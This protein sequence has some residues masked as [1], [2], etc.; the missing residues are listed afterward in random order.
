MRRVPKNVGINRASGSARRAK[1]RSS[2][3]FVVFVLVC[4]LVIGCGVFRSSEAE[5]EFA[6]LG[7]SISSEVCEFCYLV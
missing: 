2:V 1:S 7:V 3:D 6:K 5:F 4:Y